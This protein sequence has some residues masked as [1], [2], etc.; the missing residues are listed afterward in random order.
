M[1]YFAKSV[2]TEDLY[3]VQKKEFSITCY[4]GVLGAW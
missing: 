4:T 1:I 3:I 2:L